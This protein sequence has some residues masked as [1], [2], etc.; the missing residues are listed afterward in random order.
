MHV[1]ERETRRRAFYGRRRR[2]DGSPE[3]P[4][5]GDASRG[6]AWVPELWDAPSDESQRRSG[7]GP[8]YSETSGHAHADGPTL[9]RN[10]DI[11]TSRPYWM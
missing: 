7:P 4:W 8:G 5:D 11:A 3:P 2:L 1:P 9:V 10:R 6:P